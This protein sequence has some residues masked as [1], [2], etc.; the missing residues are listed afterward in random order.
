MNIEPDIFDY[1][2]TTSLEPH[3]DY[4]SEITYKDQKIIWNRLKRL[5]Q[6]LDQYKKQIQDISNEFLKY[7]W[8]NS[9]KEQIVNQL[10]SLY[11]SIFKNGGDE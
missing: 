9:T 8:E 4:T 5:H 11:T 3:D 7:D 2:E 1:L 6:E 10:K